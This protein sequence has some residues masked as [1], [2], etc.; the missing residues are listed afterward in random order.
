[1]KNELKLHTNNSLTKFSKIFPSN[2]FTS[3]YDKREGKLISKLFKHSKSKPKPSLSSYQSNFTSTSLLQHTDNPQSHSNTNNT[4]QLDKI[5][6]LYNELNLTSPHQNKSPNG[7]YVNHKESLTTNEELLPSSSS[8][9]GDKVIQRSISRKTISI[10]K[11][12]MNVFQNENNNINVNKDYFTACVTN[13]NRNKIKCLDDD[14]CNSNSNMFLNKTEDNHNNH[15][16]KYTSVNSLCNE[17]KTITIIKPSTPDINIT[18][19]PNTKIPK[20]HS[21]STCNKQL[22]KL[23]QRIQ[24][25]IIKYKCKPKHNNNS[26]TSN[27]NYNCKCKC[28]CNYYSEMDSL[29]TE[30]SNIIE[31]N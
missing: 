28:N 27:C 12:G 7:A 6:T 23:K 21:S 17:I 10:P 31:L 22:F 1:M 18:K 5:N 14:S 16:M 9:G 25:T 20:Q 3:L 24:E 19:K 4:Q 30:L 11:L 26:I 13:R 29:L 8:V 15:N 2:K